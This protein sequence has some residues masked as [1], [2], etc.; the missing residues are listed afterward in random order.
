MSHQYHPKHVNPDSAPMRAVLFR[1]RCKDNTDI[2]R[3]AP[4]HD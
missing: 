3:H 1:S 4:T 2:A